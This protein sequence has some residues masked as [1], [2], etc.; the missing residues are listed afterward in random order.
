[1]ASYTDKLPTFNPYVQQQPVEAMVEVGMAKQQQYDQGIQSIQHSMDKINSLGV[2]KDV[3]KQYIDSK[4][5]DV[6]KKLRGFAG[7]D[8]SNSNMTRSVTGM[9]SQ[10]GGDEI[11]QRSVA[12]AQKARQAR[13][14]QQEYTKSG[15]GSASNDWLLGTS[16]EAWQND[17]KAGATFNATYKPYKDF[18]KHALEI[19]KNVLKD[20]NIKD[21]DFY[22][23][24]TTGKVVFTDVMIKTKLAGKSR[25]KIQSAI[26]AGF[27]PDDWQQMEIDGRYQYSNMSGK[28]FSNE[29][30]SSY[31]KT[32]SYLTGEKSRLN[33]LIKAAA[34]PSVQNSL[35][36]SLSKIDSTLQKE[37]SKFKVL[38]NYFQK[39]EMEGAKAKLFTMNWM[40]NMS[41]SFSN[42]ENSTTIHSSPRA[43]AAFKKDK[44]RRRRKEYNW[45]YNQKQ[46]FH[47]E[48]RE[49][50]KLARE[51]SK[52]ANTLAELASGGYGSVIQH[53]E[54]S[55]LALMTPDELQNQID[56]DKESIATEQ[57][58]LGKYYTNEDSYKKLFSTN[59]NVTIPGR[60]E[61][62][63][64]TETFQQ[65]YPD[66]ESYA[67][68]FM[69]DQEQLYKNKPSSVKNKLKTF[70]S[71]K[72]KAD[73][74]IETKEHILNTAIANGE[75]R[76]D[77]NNILDEEDKGVTYN[78]SN[79]GQEFSITTEEV[80]NFNS[81]IDKL[82]QIYW[83][84][85]MDKHPM[86]VGMQSFL[87][88]GNAK[89]S[90]EFI[91]KTS[92][93]DKEK[94]LL[95]IYN[96]KG[97]ESTDA[98]VRKGYKA[99]EQTGEQQIM[100]VVRKLRDKYNPKVEQTLLDKAKYVTDNISDRVQRFQ[101]KTHSIDLQ[102]KQKPGG[103]NM[104]QFKAILEG[105]ASMAEDQGGLAL[106][107]DVE[108][109]SIS[110][111]IPTLENAT[112]TV[113]PGVKNDSGGR[114]TVH[115]ISARDRAGTSVS[116]RINQEQYKEVFPDGRYDMSQELTVFDE[117]KKRIMGVKP[118][119]E[120]TPSSIGTTAKDGKATTKDNSYLSGVDFPNTSLFGLSGNV[121]SN[122]GNNY[123]VE[124]NVYNPMTGKTM[125][126]LEFNP[127][128]QLDVDLLKQMQ[129][130]NDYQILEMI[131]GREPS[132]EEIMELVKAAKAIE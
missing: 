11:I 34:D 72:S 108:S 55:N 13:Q 17:P 123:E 102:T 68:G 6:T 21:T 109:T 93:S 2:G 126:N 62:E 15:K 50:K 95:S 31:K 83:N 99:P 40:N 10:I 41:N 90:E 19:V 48:N 89:F 46:T 116:F 111:V 28:E 114:E 29:I 124:L 23:D 66:Y 117:Y 119:E 60:Q 101:G 78:F 125:E 107:P 9:V 127:N 98:S 86:A 77:I 4:M 35:E 53:K 27:T 69:Y 7:A 105:F 33:G 42:V 30:T 104:D 118:G 12:S 58:T 14:L 63:E 24:E 57:I 82:S 36:Q 38:D 79:E 112:Y 80:L 70:F 76:F 132:K 100:S 51:I 39:G 25:E 56:S 92:L 43:E 54:Q 22:I 37:K 64:T 73:R 121:V 65:R 47:D 96:N 103:S 81:K 3:D 84:N 129:S 61:G 8:F 5:S 115:E 120:F 88:G 122:T 16:L 49:D 20:E 26:M 67:S 113:I 18:N 97:S 128:P 110:K 87:Q 91:D 106:S 45:D 94:Y 74:V 44:E 52:K 75:K 32:V 1:M 59:G 85:E 130:V 131:L 71:Q